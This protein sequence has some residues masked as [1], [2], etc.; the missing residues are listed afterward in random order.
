MT[1]SDLD[2]QA[3]GPSYDGRILMKRSIIS[4]I[5]RRS[6][7]ISDKYKSNSNPNKEVLYL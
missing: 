2:I 4:G 1:L 7:T 6:S 3:L 5:S